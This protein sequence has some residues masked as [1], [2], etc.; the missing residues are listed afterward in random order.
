MIIHVLCTLPSFPAGSP[1]RGGDVAVYVLDI[2]QP[3]SPTCFYSL[4][5]PISVF[6]ALST[7]FHSINSPDNC[8]LPQRVLLA[9]FLPYWSFELHISLWESP[10]ALI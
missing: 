7:V 3:N 5:V 9:L 2:N 10:S 1:S 6:I 8:L 4:R